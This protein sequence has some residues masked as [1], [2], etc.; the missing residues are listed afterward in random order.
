MTERRQ[1]KMQ[2]HE[3]VAEQLAI[4]H[5]GVYRTWAAGPAPSAPMTTP[6]PMSQDW[7]N[8][9]TQQLVAATA[10]ALPDTL[11]PFAPYVLAGGALAVAFFVLGGGG[12]SGRRR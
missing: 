7:I 2:L 11:K 9:R 12:S 8:Q 4:E 6:T 5:L 1:S 10:A 3:I